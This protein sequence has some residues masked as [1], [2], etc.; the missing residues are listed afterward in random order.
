MRTVHDAPKC[1]KSRAFQGR[2]RK[3]GRRG[4]I[5]KIFNA[6]GSM[7]VLLETDEELSGE[8]HFIFGLLLSAINSLSNTF[9]L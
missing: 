7:D 4:L 5:G 2:K 1:P 8:E 3:R 9:R 6:A